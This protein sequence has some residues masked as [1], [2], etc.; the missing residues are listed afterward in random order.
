MSPSCGGGPAEELRNRG[1]DRHAERARRLSKFG[2]EE[3]LGQPGVEPET[4]K[5]YQTPTAFPADP[6]VSYEL[7]DPDAVPDRRHL[8]GGIG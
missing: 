2:Q 5:G 6:P 4:V 3:T 1:G 7:I 8:A